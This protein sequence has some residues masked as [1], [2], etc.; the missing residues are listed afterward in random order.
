MGAVDFSID[1][2]LV[3]SLRRVLPISVFV[4]TGT[5][6]GEAVARARESFEEIHSVEL[7]DHYYAQA[8]ERFAGDARV[9]LYHGDSSHVLSA[10]RPTLENKAALYWLD[11]HWCVADEAAGEESQCPLLEELAALKDLNAESVVLIDDARLFLATPPYPHE[12]SHWPRM[13][14]VL[15]RLLRLSS[16]HELMVVN[17]VIVFFPAAALT[18]ASD[19]AKSYGTDWLAQVHQLAVLEHARDQLEDVAAERL[20]AIEELAHE[21]DLQAATARERLAAIE[22]LAHE[23]DFQAATARERLAVIEELTRERDL[24]A[25]ES[26]HVD[27]R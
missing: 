11:A 26:H 9:T 25:Q 2:R 21:R 13:Q 17:D 7:S 6:E 24:A 20:A 10:L 1:M 23:R 18:A 16:D 5:F 19:Y 22:E 4:E 3:E 14:E 15:E 8:T 12:S 27:D